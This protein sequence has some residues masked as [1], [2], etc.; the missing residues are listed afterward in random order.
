MNNLEALR[1]LEESNSNARNAAECVIEEKKLSQTEFASIR[2]RFQELKSTRRDFVRNKDLHT[3]EELQFI[4][5]GQLSRKRKSSD[6]KEIRTP[7]LNL[8]LKKI[9]TRIEPLLVR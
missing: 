7:L 6:G 9:R 8:Q 3:W 2:S 1:I 4:G 5:H